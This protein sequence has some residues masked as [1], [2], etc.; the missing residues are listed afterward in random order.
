LK[1]T[2]REKSGWSGAILVIVVISLVPVLWI[3]SLSFKD[4]STIGDGNF[5]PSKWSW[6]NYKGIF[7]QSVF[8]DALRNSIGI[9]LISTI[10]AV[11]I[12]SFAAYAIARLTSRASAF[13]SA[14][15]WRSPCSR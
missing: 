15:R 2:A 14:R 5:F 4:P 3:V 9:A 1:Y 8:T 6:A 13:S 11:V 10:F 12:A 7:K